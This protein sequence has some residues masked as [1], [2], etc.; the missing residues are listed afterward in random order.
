VVDDGVV[1]E[2]VMGWEEGKV[3]LTCG[4][5]GGAKHWFRFG[6]TSSDFSYLSC[7]Q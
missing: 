3:R 6:R 4:E 2:D 7:L 1:G 5:L